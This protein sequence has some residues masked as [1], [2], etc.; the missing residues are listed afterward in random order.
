MAA[1]DLNNKVALVT[2]GARGIGFGTARALIARGASVVIVDLDQAAVERA[3]GELHD[4]RALGLA[5]D[6]TDRGALQRAVAT[7]VERFGGLDVVVANAGIVSRVASF[8]AM[9]A[10]NFERVLD[11]NLMGV[12]RTV[13]AALPEIVP[14]KGH[15]VVISSIY[16]FFN[17]IG[18]VPYA[19]SK[20]AVEQFGRALRVE[21]TPHGASATVAYFGFI[22]TEM[23]H[24]AL[25][26]DPL[27]DRLLEA[28]P[29]PLHKRLSPAVAGEAIVRGIEQRRPRVI[30]PRRWAIWSVL[31]GI[32]NPLADARAERDATTHEIVRECDARVGEDQ[33]TTA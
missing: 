15:V 20:A 19:M 25:D 16:A 3:A 28:L 12:C 2:G 4:T 33:P 30:R 8:R 6:V 26:Q 1:Y 13:E 32:I 24:R 31:R 18:A 10:E 14:R 7:T 21:L 29:K 5:A 17:G 11:V 27:V 9:S 22:D 23:V